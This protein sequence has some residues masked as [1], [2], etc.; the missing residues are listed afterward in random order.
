MGSRK[1]ITAAATAAAALFVCAPGAVAAPAGDARGG[2]QWLL[3]SGSDVWRNGSF[4]H[5]GL[6]WSPDGL[7]REG[8][9]LK[10]VIS[11][12]RYRYI[13]GALGNVE[14][15]GRELAAQIMP[16]A[17]FKRGKLEIKVFAGL[18]I[19][20][21][22]LSPDDPSSDLRG[23]DIGARLAFDLWHEPTP[24]I[25]LAADGSLS[26]IAG[27]YSARVAAGWRLFNRFYA[28]PEAQAFASEDYRQTR[29]G[30]HLTGFK[31]GALEWSLAAGWADDNDGRDGLYGRFGVSARH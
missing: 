8:F 20:D 11:G 14:V 9:T 25:M 22:S 15:T 24:Q 27:S 10:A 1:R 26:S 2:A 6:L 28:G 13:S 29:I 7:D 23:G 18:D 12:G 21:H 4:F 19:Q 16:G 5:G 3:F 30:L 31:T 17:R